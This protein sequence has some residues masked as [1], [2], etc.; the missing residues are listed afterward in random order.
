[1]NL[2]RLALVWSG[3]AIF[4]LTGLIAW[5]ALL[6]HEPVERVLLLAAPQGLGLAM[7]ALG[8]TLPGRKEKTGGSF[9]QQ[10][11]N[12]GQPGPAAGAKNQH[13]NQA[14]PGAT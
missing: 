11:G 1:M 12:H 6:T 8:R 9:A 7:V 3:G 10:R 2:S 5:F 14:E 13:G 4:V